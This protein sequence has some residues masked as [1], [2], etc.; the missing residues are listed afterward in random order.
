[1]AH[2]D[3]NLVLLNS[4]SDLAEAYM[5]KGVLETNGIECVIHNENISSV[6]PVTMI[7]WGQIDIMV[8][9]GDINQARA[10]LESPAEYNDRS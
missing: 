4:Y 3:D 1:M 9:Q 5:V 6:Y 2:T 10:I 7:A 8:R